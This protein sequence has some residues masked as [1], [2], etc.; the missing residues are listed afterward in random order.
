MRTRATIRRLVF[1]GLVAGALCAPATAASAQVSA[2]AP[3]PGLGVRLLQGP[4]D[5]ADDPR[6][7]EYIVDHLAPGTTI[8]RQ[9]GFTNGDPE[10]ADLSFYAAAA[11]IHDGS[12]V[13]GAG[14]A[15]NELTSWITFSPTSATLAPGESLPVTVTIAVPVGATA[16]ERYAAALAEHAFPAAASGGVSAVSR[17]GIRIYLSVGAGGAAITDFS[18]DSMTAHRDAD[19]VPYVTAGIHNTGER[20]VDLSGELELTDGPAS[21]SAGPFPVRSVATLAVGGSGTVTIMLDPDLPDG[22]WDGRLTLESGRISKTV[23]GRLL[24]PTANGTSA[25]PTTDLRSG[26]NGSRWLV[27]VILLLVFLLL[28]ILLLA[29]RRREEEEEPPVLVV[30]PS[31]GPVERD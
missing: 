1:V 6:T 7:H 18:I 25:A 30:T 8:S 28:L 2:P 13:P 9:I 31:R 14:H 15:P 16:G 20:A 23:T 11:E 12:F 24:F 26:G 27:F 10:A 21:L 3:P 4:A 22:P 29:R 17:V 5:G 19:G